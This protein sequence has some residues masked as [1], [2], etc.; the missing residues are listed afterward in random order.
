MAENEADRWRSAS[1]QRHTGLLPALQQASS[2]L[3]E[4]ISKRSCALQESSRR[5]RIMEDRLRGLKDDAIASWQAVYQAEDMVTMRVEEIMQN[6]SREREMR[7]LDQLREEEVKQQQDNANGV[8]GATSEEIWDIVSSV[9]ESMDNGSFEPLD[10]PQAPLSTP[11]DKSR[12]EDS[13]S[14][15][16]AN[17]TDTRDTNTTS[18]EVIP[19]ASRENIELEVRLPELRAA[20]MT[21]DAVEDA[22]GSLLNIISNLTRHDVPSAAGMP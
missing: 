7:R 9:A 11:R 3:K 5:A 8:L 19:L 1:L 4:R 12:D 18:V 20:A 6:R 17:L 22:A 15:S 2:D 13:P 14:V 21:D 16:A 10:M